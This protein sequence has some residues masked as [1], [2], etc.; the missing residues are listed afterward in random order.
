[1]TRPFV[2]VAA[3]GAVLG[4]GLG[5]APAEAQLYEAQ[6]RFEVTPIAGY[7][8]GGSFDT[9][10]SNAL[11]SGE[12]QLDDSF[13]WGAIL[14]FIAHGHSALELTYLHQG[15]Q[16]GFDPV[17]S[18]PI[19]R[20]ADFSM[21]YIQIGGRQEFPRGKLRPFISGSLG[22]NVLDL[23]VEG[24]GSETRFSWGIG[25]GFI[26]NIG[27]SNRFGIRTDVKFWATPVPSGDYGTWC[28][29]YGCFVV[30]GTEWITQG[31]ATGGL[32]FAF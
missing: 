20:T 21:N 9:D 19:S 7:Q 16:L 5:A 32:V 17:G 3:V 10:A 27:E 1:M 30:E 23:Q 11:P 14:S 24:F 29:Y 15:T 26:Y 2:L 31:Q 8:W 13:A 18:P 22:I 25:G 28:D 4:L 12:L 6:P